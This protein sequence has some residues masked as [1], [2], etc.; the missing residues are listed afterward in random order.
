MLVRW[1]LAQ[2]LKCLTIFLFFPWLKFKQGFPIYKNTTQNSTQLNTW[3]S[4]LS[5]PRRYLHFTSM[6][7]FSAVPCIEFKAIDVL[8]ST[9]KL[10]HS[11]MLRNHVHMRSQLS[12]KLYRCFP[13]F[14]AGKAKNSTVFFG[15]NEY[16]K[17][18]WSSEFWSKII[19]IFRCI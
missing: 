8:S 9:N 16:W 14:F 12:D 10:V 11:N 3:Q 5:N 13:E 1:Q 19:H 4:N 7:I 15:I 17:E 6:Q 18:N 2:Y